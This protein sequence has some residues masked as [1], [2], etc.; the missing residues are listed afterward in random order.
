MSWV[1]AAI[2]HRIQQRRAADRPDGGGRVYLCAEPYWTARSAAGSEWG[3]GL[4]ERAKLIYPLKLV[5]TV[6]ILRDTIVELG[7]CPLCP[8]QRIA[9]NSRSIEAVEHCGFAIA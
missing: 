7:N 3:A 5:G 2:A 1:A 6:T 9:A 8:Q 4:A